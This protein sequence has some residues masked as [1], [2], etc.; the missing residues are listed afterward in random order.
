M[1]VQTKTKVKRYVAYA[2]ILLLAHILQNS[3]PIFP[4]ILAVRPV[5]LI[6][7]AVCMS[8]FEGE[9]VGAIAGLV[10]GALWD[11]VTATADGYNAFYL[12]VACAVCG[13]ML[14]IFMRNNIVT[15]IM[16]NTGVTMVYFLTYVLFFITARGIDGGTEMLLR[17][18]LPMSIYSLLLTPLWYVIIRAVNRKFSSNYTE[19]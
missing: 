9:L 11:T 2:V 17:Y 5:L 13:V 15:Y 18:Y 19:Y 3:L 12:M 10:A 8:M 6:S 16:M 1:T 7:A 14:R 4:E